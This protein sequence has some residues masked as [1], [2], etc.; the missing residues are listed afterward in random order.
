MRNSRSENVGVVSVIVSE[1]EFS[2]VQMQIFVADLMECS[3]NAALEDRPEA[4]NR[5]RMNCADDMLTNG[6]VNRL[7]REAMLQPHIAWV[8]VSAEQADAIR[9][10]FAD[11]SLKRLSTSV[12]DNASNDVAF[13]LDRANYGSLAGVAAPALA[14]FLVPMPVLIAP[15]N[16]GLINLD[17]AAKFLDVLDH[18]GS[19]LVAHEPS[20]LVAAEAHI[21]EDLEGAHA[22]LADQHQVRD[23]VPIFQRLIRVLKDC[24][25]QVREAITCG[26]ARCAYRALPMVAGSE[27]ID[28]EVTAARAGNALWPSPRYQINDAIVLSLKQ[29]V[30]LGRCHLMNCFGAR[31]A[32]TPL[33]LR[34]MA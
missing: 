32:E 10:G 22:L 1:L 9:Y 6:V 15:A 16:V 8:G 2:N 13:A 24:A 5:I 29:R 7:V 12:F 30:E 23:S 18:G 20:G 28:L 26:T 27:G 33:T 11:E 25:G 31:H 21:T 4:F 3:D 17:D 34:N 19:D 14:A